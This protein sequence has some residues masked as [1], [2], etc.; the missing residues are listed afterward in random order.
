MCLLA[1][2]IHHVSSQALTLFYIAANTA[3]GYDLAPAL[4][5]ISNFLVRTPLPPLVV[6]YPLPLTIFVVHRVYQLCLL[7]CCAY[8]LA[9]PAVSFLLPHQPPTA[10]AVF[11]SL[12]ACGT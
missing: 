4:R 1:E 9:S 12:I 2:S 5:S 7:C 11:F 8:V 3:H 6:A 10:S